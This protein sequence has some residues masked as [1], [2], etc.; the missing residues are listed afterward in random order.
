[1][2]QEPRTFILVDSMN[3]Y[4]RAKHFGKGG[5]INIK[6]GMAMHTIFNSLRKL[7]RIASTGHVVMCME[8]NSWRYKHLPEYKLPRK[9]KALEASPAQQEEDAIFLESFLELINYMDTKTNATVLK[10]PNSEG[11]DLIALWCQSHP[12]DNNIIVSS[13][14][15]YYQLISE[16]VTV[17]NGVTEE[18]ITLDG[19]FDS[20]GKRVEKKGDVDPEWFLFEKCIR[21]DKS[22][23][24]HSAYPGV[25]T[26]GSSKKVGIREAFLDKNN[27][28]FNWNNFMLQRWTDPDGVEHRV[29]DRYEFNR[30]MI[31]L[32]QQPEEIKKECLLAIYE[33]T[34]K[35]PVQGIGI[36]FLK[37]CQQWDLQRIS[38]TPDD[39][40]RVLQHRY[41]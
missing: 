9:L 3:L 27:G 34:Q 39:F 4:F 26:N 6:I 17:Y 23:N 36:H 13:D 19:V 7:Y 21:G 35:K 25:R 24:I 11:D 18:T 2:K 28:G 8:G 31:D 20:K 5:D 33:G 38:D 1:M 37:F 14:Q 12:D 10:A 41:K 15:D 29:R 22:D 16:N 30:F 40:V 32:T